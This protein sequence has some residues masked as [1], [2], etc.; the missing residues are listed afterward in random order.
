[1]C[2]Q[3]VLVLLECKRKVTKLRAEPKTMATAHLKR[4]RYA[5]RMMMLE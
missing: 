1:M 4:I 3:S 5:T 2:N